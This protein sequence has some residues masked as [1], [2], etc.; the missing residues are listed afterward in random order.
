MISLRRNTRMSISFLTI[1]KR[2]SKLR[3]SGL[4]MI[5]TMEFI[6]LDLLPLRKHMEKLL[7][8]S[9]PLWIG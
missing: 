2:K 7:L 3:M 5:S 9:L 1:Y 6:D 4:I 8:N